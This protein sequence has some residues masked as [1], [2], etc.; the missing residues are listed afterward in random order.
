[1]GKEGQVIHAK[2]KLVEKY[3]NNTKGKGGFKETLT[4]RFVLL[5][6]LF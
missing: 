6:I 2:T 5:F 4:T 3:G 1:M